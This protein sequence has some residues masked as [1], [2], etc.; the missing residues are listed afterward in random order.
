MRISVEVGHPAHVHYWRNAIRILK[1]HGHDVVIFAREKEI[2]VRL[3]RAYGLEFSLVGRSRKGLLRKMAGLAFDDLRVLRAAR[4][5]SVDFMLSTGIPGSAHASRVL[6]VPHVALIDTEVAILGRLLT[7]PFS[8]AVCTPACFTG[9][10]VG[11]RHIRLR[12]YLELMYLRPNYFVP[13]PSALSLL[14]VERDEE[15]VLVRFSSTD[16]SHDIGVRE[17]S[18]AERLSLVSELAERY[19][20][21]VSSEVP[22]PSQFRPFLLDI[23]PERFHDI[24]S[25]ARAY[26]GEGAKTASEAGV[27]GIPWIYLSRS[28]R[29][30]LKDMESRFSLGRCIESAEQVRPLLASWA[31]EID[32]GAWVRRRNRLLE[33]TEDVTAFM[34]RLIE[35]WP[36][37]A[38]RDRSGA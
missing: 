5:L 12:G 10:V 7:E 25:F 18:M 29:G 32:D 8:D 37:L 30:Y 23:P 6:N 3:L 9:R 1:G 19:R 35:E 16:S 31:N 13:D 2:T 4:N 28:P 27:L 24:L 33:E 36:D 17:M 20:V 22:L 26:V 38:W 14:G 15:F 21:F 11:A 34:V